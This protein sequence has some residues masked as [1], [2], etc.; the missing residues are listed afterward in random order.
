MMRIFLSAFILL[1]IGCAFGQSIDPNAIDIVRDTWGVP[2]IFSKTDPEVAYG[3]AWANAEDDFRTIQLGYMAGKEMLGRYTGKQGAQVDYVVR[4]LGCRELVNER[5]ERDVSPP[6]QA[7]LQAYCDGINSYAKNHPKEIL[8]KHVFPVTP[9]DMLTYSIL[10]LAF[11]CGV[12]GALSQINKGTIP[13][14]AWEPGGSNGYAFNSRITADSSTY[15]A[16]NSHQPLEGPVAWYEAHL[17]SEEGWN[18]LGALF[19]GSPSMLIGCNE[20]LAWTHTVNYPDKLD[21]YQLEINPNNKLQYKFDGEWKNL[22]V[23]TVKLKVKLAGI[24]IGVSRK[25]Y[26]SIYGPT[27]VT[28]HGTF[29]IRTGALM[30]I[31]ALEEWYHMN[32]ARNFH[33]FSSALRMGALPGYNVIYADRYDTIYYLSNGK[34]PLRDPAFN[35]KST[36]PGNTSKTLW[37]DFH[38]LSDLPQV[39][40]PPS[41]YLFNS[42]HTPYNATSAAD[43]IK[44]KDFDPTMGY[45]T[46]NNNRSLRFMELMQ[47]IDKLDYDQFRKIKFDRQLPSRLA[48]KTNCDSLFLISESDYPDLEDLIKVLK[49]WDHVASA[50]SRGAA[51]FLIIYYKV[52]SEQ[53]AGA[54]YRSLTKAKSVELLRYA[55]SYISQYFGQTPLTLGQYQKLVRGTKEVPLPGVPDVISSMR[56]VPYKDGKVRGEQGD[57]YIELVRF[58]PHGPEIE[59]VNCY[60]SSSKK[61]AVHYD[62]QMEMF[63][64]QKTKPM[65]LDK[66]HVYRDAKAVYH[67]R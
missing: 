59:S 25:V 57:S 27:M 8:L 60:G 42:N 12:D 63:V 14:S 61:G 36:L 23:S 44:E 2:H 15:L 51:I 55:K 37:K 30:E 7:I 4:L 32:K 56:S 47:G 18:I 9:R 24:V 40:Q 34:L 46:N 19:P 5:F 45:E 48:Y 31:R 41:G 22:D 21:V 3:L 58:T 38:P 20:N 64:Q 10:Q 26:N 17:C 43:N 28:P 49:T 29:S 16:I 39:L 54:P 53:E 50:D 66:A 33:E 1:K 6:Y 65:T 35:W 11:S 13:L 52:T 62:D 67:P